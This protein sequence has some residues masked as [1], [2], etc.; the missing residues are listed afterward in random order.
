VT[1]RAVAAAVVFA[2]LPAQCDKIMGKK[3]PP[4][5][6]DPPPTAPVVVTSATTPPVWHPPEPPQTAPPGSGSAKPPPDAN[7]DLTKAKAAADAKDFKKVKAILSPKA[8]KLAPEEAQL[9]FHA[10]MQLKD[11]ACADGV[12]KTH[13]DVTE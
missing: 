8:K 2:L 3:P 12:K 4:T 5:D 10:C 7:P 11:K 6:P 1:S 9:L 13:P